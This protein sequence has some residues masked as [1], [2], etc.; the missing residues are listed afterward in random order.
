MTDRME[1]EAEEYFEQ[2]DEYGGVIPALEAGFQQR[3]IARA[4]YR[5]QMEIESGKRITV[6][7]NGYIDRDE[8]I[9]IPILKITPD[10]EKRQVA[11]LQEVRKKRDSK[12]VKLKL[13]QLAGAVR[14]EENLMPF[15]IECAHAYV[16]LGEMIGVLKEAYGEYRETAVF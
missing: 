5:H 15:F 7:V 13:S 8:T 14:S 2:I 4:A 6:G 1:A 3:E 12:E 10:V 16:T 11:N 9:D